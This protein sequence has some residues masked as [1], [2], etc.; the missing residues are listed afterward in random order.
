MGVP[1]VGTAYADESLDAMF[2]TYQ[3]QKS[4]F[5]VAEN[6]RAIVGCG[7]IAPLQGYDETICELQKMYVANEQQGQGLGGKILTKCLEAAKSMGYAGCYLET[8]PFMDAAQRLYR[9]NGFDYLKAPLGN[10]GHSACTVRM[11]VNF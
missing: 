1:K 4:I 2:E 10:T 8:M 7:G 9:K 5:Y 6:N 11:L 3:R